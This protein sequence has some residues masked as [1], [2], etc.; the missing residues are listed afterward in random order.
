MIWARRP[1]LNDGGQQTSV[2]DPVMYKYSTIFPI[3]IFRYPFTV[4]V[5]H[6][7]TDIKGIAE[8]VSVSGERNKGVRDHCLLFVMM[9]IST[10]GTLVQSI[11][12]RV[13]QVPRLIRHTLPFRI[14]SE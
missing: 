4:G 14:Q 2:C 1:G 6:I 9:L 5:F 12:I 7:E 8:V 3:E 11:E 13:A 10:R